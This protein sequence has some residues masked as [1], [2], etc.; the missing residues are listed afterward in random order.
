LVLERNTDIVAQL[1]RDIDR[2]SGKM[3]D[4]FVQM[5][6]INSVNPRMGG[7]GETERAGFIKKYLEREGFDTQQLDAPDEDYKDKVRPNISA[8]IIGKDE[9]RTLWFLSHMDTV[10]E[11]SRELWKTDPFEPV[12]SDGKIYARGA[13]DNGQSL[14]ASLFALRAIKSRREDLP[15]NVGIW[16]VA[17]EE[18]GSKYGVKYLLQKKL[19]SKNDLIVVPDAGFPDGRSVE[20]AE[21]NLLWLKITVSGK[22]VHASVPS[23]GKNARRIGMELALEIDQKLHKKYTKTNKLFDESRSTFE[24]TMIQANVANINT[25]PGKDVFC[26]DC[27]VL[28]EY[29]LDGVLSDINTIM[30]KYKKKE[31]TEIKL[32]AVNREDAGPATSPK[33][34]VSRLLEAA[35]AQVRKKKP[36]FVGIGGQTVGNLFRQEGLATA[37]WSTVDDVPHEPNEYSK[38]ENLV[39]DAKVFAAM[40]F[41]GTR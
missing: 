4:F 1:S 28:P 16:C 41:A 20:I 19:F 5:L 21:K 22:Q 35:I 34:E 37:V 30:A 14:V 11:G 33:S 26:F 13:E 24:P 12:V 6:R 31:R 36:R 3:Q 8:K 9:S 25:I 18:Y 17:D 39:S 32:D 2:D 10:P 15:F 27:R 40:P 23:K 7:P 38:I 29:P